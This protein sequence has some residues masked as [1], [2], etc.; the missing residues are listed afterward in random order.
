MRWPIRNQIFL[1][2]ATLLLVAI[3]SIAVLLAAVAARRSSRERMER[4]ERVVATLNDASFPFTENVLTKMQGLSGAEYVALDER[5]AIVT[6]TLGT[7][8]RASDLPAR[9]PVTGPPTRL[10]DFQVI[11]VGGQP[12]F[13][14]VLKGHANAGVHSLLVLYP[15]SNLW[16]AQW[17]AAWP[18]LA[19]GG[20]TILLMVAVSAWLSQRLARRIEAV[21]G[22]FARL[23]DGHFGHVDAQRP[24]DEIYD[25]ILSANRLSDRLA[26]NQEEIARTERLRLLAQLAG[27][28]AHQL[29]NSVTGARMAVQLHQRRCPRQH[30]ESLDVALRQLSLTEEQVRGFLSLGKPE[31]QPPVAQSLSR[32]VGEVDRLVAPAA[33]HGHVAWE[34]E[35]P[36]A[37]DDPTVANAHSVRAGLLNLALNAVQAA[38]SGGSA[39]PAGSGGRVRLSTKR[40]GRHVQIHVA[41][42]GSGPPE[43]LRSSMFEPFITSKP[44]GIGLGL[45]LAK[46]AAEEHGGSL[47]FARVDGQTRFTM[48]LAAERPQPIAMT[49]AP[50]E[51]EMNLSTTV[52]A[53]SPH[54]ESRAAAENSVRD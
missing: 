54:G 27:G 10:E 50:T 46:A 4:V 20:V 14:A 29:R 21:Q 34:C 12:Y 26:S 47:T 19:I 49:E 8:V 42:S 7:S 15:K 30:D 22:L 1:P 9:L 43:S 32:I 6:S 39:Q 41:D 35:P 33:R 3:A 40:A 23:A 24:L 36:A 45:A 51:R 18:P 28:L 17:A 44:E 16:Q 52:A 2:V 53:V 37:D 31:Q 48:S 5:G 25:L 38:G 13:L 11:G